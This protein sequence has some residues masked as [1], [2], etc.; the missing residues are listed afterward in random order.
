VNQQRTLLGVGIVLI[1]LATFAAPTQA[2]TD[3]QE[4]VFFSDDIDSDPEDVEGNISDPAVFAQV[5]D[6]SYRTTIPNYS[7]DGTNVN[8]FR[9]NQIEAMETDDDTSY[10]L[11]DS[12]VQDSAL[13]EDIHITYAGVIGGAHPRLGAGHG[14]FVSNEGTI[15]NHFDYRYVDTPD[16]YCTSPTWDTHQEDIDGDND[17]ETVYDD[18]DYT[19]YLYSATRDSDRWATIDGDRFDGGQTI[20]YSG[21]EAREAQITL[22]GEANMTVYEESVP[23]DWDPNS[24]DTTSRSDGDWDSG[25]GS[26]SEYASDSVSVSDSQN[27]LFTDNNWMEVNQTV[28]EVEGGNNRILLDF[29]APHDDGEVDASLLTGRVLWSYLTFGDSA[30]INGPWATYSIR[31]HREGYER[32]ASGSDTI[33]DPPHPL[34]QYLFANNRQPTARGVG[35][36]TDMQVLQYDGYDYTRMGSLHSNVD[37]DYQRPILYDRLLIANPP[38]PASSLV[39]IHGNQIDIDVD[40]RVEYREPSVSISEGSGSEVL[41]RVE[42]P[43]TGNPLSG[44]NVSLYGTDIDTGTTNSSGYINATRENAFVRAS[45]ASDNWSEPDGAV[46]Y[47]E[48]AAEQTFGSGGVVLQRLYSLVRMAVFVSPLILLYFYVR[49]FGFFE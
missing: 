7:V 19:C 25:S 43:E 31:E 35:D 49:T 45:V 18:G 8:D 39:T 27:V 9:T 26:T 21:I 41:I 17:T 32:T 5:G 6:I 42:D 38:E 40:N 14:T 15:L 11:P 28:I 23:R 2:L 10:V 24:A 34:R 13:I 1:L 33:S 48:A 16:N 4:L 37:L 29:E 46:F 3:E 22:H 44:R 12:N 36:Q 20:D 30:Y 47:G